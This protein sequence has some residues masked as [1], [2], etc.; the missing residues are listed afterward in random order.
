[1]N[2]LWVELLT[3]GVHDTH[4]SQLY[5]RFSIS[6]FRAYSRMILGACCWCAL[7]ITPQDPRNPRI[8]ATVFFFFFLV[9]DRGFRRT[10]TFLFSKLRVV[11]LK[12]R[13]FR[14]LYPRSLPPPHSRASLLP[15]P[16]GIRSRMLFIFCVRTTAG[17]EVALLTHKRFSLAELLSTIATSTIAVSTIAQL[18]PL[19]LQLRTAIIRVSTQQ[20]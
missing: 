17:M 2:G 1:M 11:V 15:D 8:D 12:C 20:R 19:K 10:S 14:L 6:Y 13:R 9:R 5:V 16:L 7:N 3:K 4:S 18:Q